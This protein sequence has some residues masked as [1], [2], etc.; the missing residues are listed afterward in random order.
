MDHLDE[1]KMKIRRYDADVIFEFD[2]LDELREFDTSYVTDTRSAIIK[3]VARQLGCREQDIV[4]VTSYKDK[5]NAA[6][7]MRFYV[8][9]QQY[10]YA[11][12]DKT[13]TPI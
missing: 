8:N 10:H 13:L 11:Y 3:S 4:R 1:L 5:D 9:D 7:G 6:A 12:C 2:T